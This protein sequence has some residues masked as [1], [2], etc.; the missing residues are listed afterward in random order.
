MNVSVAYL[1]LYH[2][3][4][5]SGG[6]VKFGRWNRPVEYEEQITLT[7]TTVTGKNCLRTAPIHKCKEPLISIRHN[8]F[9]SRNPF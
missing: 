3:R 7:E 6:D 1:A 8:L 4:F 5:A 9:F 2:S